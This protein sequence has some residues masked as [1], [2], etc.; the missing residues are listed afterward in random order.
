MKLKDSSFLTEL[1]ILGITTLTTFS[2]P[3]QAFILQTS[4][5]PI[6]NPPFDSYL[7]IGY[8]QTFT[9]LLGRNLTGISLSSSSFNTNSFTQQGN[10]PIIAN[11]FGG[12]V[13]PGDGFTLSVE[14]EDLPTSTNI[15]VTSELVFFTGT[16]VITVPDQRITYGAV[17]TT[18][19]DGTPFMAAQIEVEAAGSTYQI[20]GQCQGNTLGLINN[21]IDDYDVA[22]SVQDLPNGYQPMDNLDPFPPSQTITLSPGFNQDV[23]QTTTTPEPSS[24]LGLG[25]FAGLGLIGKFKNKFISKKRL[26]S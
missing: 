26:L 20:L 7:I 5:P 12:S 16:G 4:V 18:Q 1:A 11:Y 24:I 23:A 15:N 8:R 21:Q 10:N 14:I 2:I 9:D 6:S 22:I 17:C 25:L 3:A 13:L 19:G